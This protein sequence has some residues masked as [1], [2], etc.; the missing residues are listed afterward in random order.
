[1]EFV[2]GGSCDIVNTRLRD[3]KYRELQMLGYGV[4]AGDPRNVRWW[5]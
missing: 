3:V 5:T 4:G 2:R 1:V